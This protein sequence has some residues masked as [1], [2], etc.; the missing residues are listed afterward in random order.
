[1]DRRD[2]LRL[3]AGSIAF[4]ACG[5]GNEPAA[6]PAPA[7]NLSVVQ[8][9]TEIA[10]GDQR[11]DLAVLEPAGKPRRAKLS[12]MTLV[13]PDDQPVPSPQ[14]Q[15]EKIRRDLGGHSHGAEVDTIYALHRTFDTQGVHTLQAAAGAM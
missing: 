1:M 6:T 7:G 15:A 10:V 9:S 4:A 13:G 11:A 14:A 8:V 12:S 2:F 3:T 5:K